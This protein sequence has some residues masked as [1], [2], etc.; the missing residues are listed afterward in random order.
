MKVKLVIRKPSTGEIITKSANQIV[1]P[2]NS[3]LEV[4]KCRQT[5]LSSLRVEGGTGYVI[6]CSLCQKQRAMWEGA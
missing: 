4:H 5:P 2:Q 1:P 6:K 3:T